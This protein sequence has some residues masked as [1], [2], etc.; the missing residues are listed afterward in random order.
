MEL[1]TKSNGNINNADGPVRSDGGTVAFSHV[2]FISNPKYLS[3]NPFD[4][5]NRHEV[6]PVLTA[7]FNPHCHI[8]QCLFIEVLSL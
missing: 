1:K 5:P 7:C 8:G 4:I 3:P 2:Q 6:C